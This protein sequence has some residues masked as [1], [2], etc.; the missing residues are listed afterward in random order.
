MICDLVICDWRFGSLGIRDLGFFD[1]QL[2]ADDRLQ[3]GL[4][5]GLME[6]GRSVDAVGIEQRQRGVAKRRGALD[7]RF[8][9]RGAA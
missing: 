5:R 2:R 9:Q 4:A 3:A 8:G 6:A 1:R 7:E